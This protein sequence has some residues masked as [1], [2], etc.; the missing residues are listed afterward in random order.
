MILFQIGE[1]T[2]GIN[3]FPDVPFAS[4]VPKLFILDAYNY[5]TSGAKSYIAT[6]RTLYV[7]VKKY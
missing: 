2:I 5:W 4:T 1:Y 7:R 3:L 6:P